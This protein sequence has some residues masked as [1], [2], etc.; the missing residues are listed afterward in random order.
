MDL[1]ERPTLLLRNVA[2]A[3][4]FQLQLDIHNSIE[5]RIREVQFQLAVVTDNR[6]HAI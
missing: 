4:G 1:A 3:S 5:K 2:A 6:P